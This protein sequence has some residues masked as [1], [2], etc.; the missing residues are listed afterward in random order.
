VKA[1]TYAEIVMTI[2]IL[3]QAMLNFEL[4]KI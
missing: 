2:W 3:K 4:H 1:L